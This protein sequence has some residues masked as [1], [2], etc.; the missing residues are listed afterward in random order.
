MSQAL[1]PGT[2]LGPYAIKALIGQGGM[3]E[4]YRAH[5]SRLKRDVALKVLP[6]SVAND[7]DRLARFEREAQTL[8]A[9]N[10]PHIA[11]IHGI[12]ESN[13]IRALVMELV[14]GPTLADRIAKGPIPFDE[15]LPM[16]RQIAEA[17]EAAHQAG[18]IHRDL[19][20]ANIKLRPDSTVK[21]LDFGL[22]KMAEP[23]A[24]EDGVANS[25]T[26]TS[27]AMM[28]HTGVILGTAAYMAPEQARGKPVDRRADIWAFGCVLYESLTGRH[29]FDGSDLTE[30]LASVLRSEPDYS[31]LPATAVGLRPLIE[32]CLRK[33]PASRLAHMSVA[34]FLLETVPSLDAP[35]P[36]ARKRSQGIIALAVLL[37]AVATYAASRFWSAGPSA[38]PDVQLERVSLVLPRQVSTIGHSPL[39]VSE[40]GSIV[41]LAAASAGSPGSLYLRRRDSLDAHAIVGTEFGAEPTLD[42]TGQ[43]IAY[44]AR[45]T[46]KKV[47]V[48]G[49]APVTLCD[50]V[51]P[52]GLAW[53]ASGRIYFAPDQGRDG[54]W[55]VSAEGGTPVR[56]TTVDPNRGEGAHEYPAPL[57]DDSGVI[58]N[59]L[60]RDGDHK[61]SNIVLLNF[62]TASTTVLVEGGFSP[63][64]TREHLAFARGNALYGGR[65]DFKQQRISGPIVRFVDG[66]LTNTTNGTAH[67]ALAR[68]AD[69]MVYQAGLDSGSR[70]P[71]WTDSTGVDRRAFPMS[72]G[73]EVAD[74]SPDGKRVA[75]LVNVSTIGPTQIW[76]GDPARGVLT[77]FLTPGE[78]LASLRWA[79]DNERFAFTTVQTGEVRVTDLNGKTEVVAKTGLTTRVDSWSPDGQSV[80]VTITNPKTATDIARVDLRTHALTMVIQTDAAESNGQV[81][82]NGRWLAYSTN[83]STRVEIEV[84]PYPGGGEPVQVSN[85]GA[86][87][88][89]WSRDGRSLFFMDFSGNIMRVAVNGTGSSV[90]Q[91]V[92][93]SNGVRRPYTAWTDGSFLR[94]AEP[95]D[96]SGEP[97]IAVRG[98]S[99]LLN[100]SAAASRP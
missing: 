65:F 14:E 4:V 45:N 48:S 94:V 67:Y 31:A 64:L 86:S 32:R 7:A 66:V 39:T 95:P 72:H 87:N 61:L 38:S 50:L 56:V 30:T 49:G 43:W 77:R 42:P 79:P 81:S 21:V 26:F 1:T 99:A 70:G 2:S 91:Q 40:D 60:P 34:Q 41:V 18:I 46:L 6:A 97:L 80:F 59:V 8:A 27:P 69:V 63:T 85:G 29:A 36:Q 20:P 47:S 71:V 62:A 19:K 92:A 57:P 12:E 3:G 25:P 17:L 55:A 90:P 83:R 93:K 15:A 24:T 75:A 78:R 33:D 9:L 58:F 74:L 37:S 35:P 76:T 13:G 11:A 89:L 84:R 54:I 28:T 88:P 73:F 16:A 5:D 98:V 23:S 82:P 44:Q 96:S 22:A 52:H 68:G 10:H 51:H 100:S 53:S